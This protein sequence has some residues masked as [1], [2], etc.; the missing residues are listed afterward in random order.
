VLYEL[1]WIICSTF[2]RVLYGF[3]SFGRRNVPKTG[4]VILAINHASFLDPVAVGCGITRPVHFMARDTLFVSLFGS[5][6]RGL[7]AFPVKRGASDTKALKE[8]IS[9]VR[10]GKVVMLFPEGTRT[11][12]GRIQRLMSGVGMIAVRAGV[13]VVPTYIAGSYD[14]WNRHHS[15]PAHAQISI[16][17]GR[18]IPVDRAEGESKKQ[19]QERVREAIEARL[20]EMEAHLC[21]TPQPR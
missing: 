18:P 10:D 17:Y 6:I 15:L 14:A 1:A 21:R 16:Y 13:P 5:L 12:N 11:S 9:R 8:Y 19:H 4:G 2:L 20:L 3:K 7:N